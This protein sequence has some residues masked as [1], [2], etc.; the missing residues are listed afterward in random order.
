MHP[1]ITI[2]LTLFS[3]RSTLLPSCCSSGLDEYTCFSLLIALSLY[4]LY[5]VLHPWGPLRALVQMLRDRNETMP[6]TE[7]PFEHSVVDHSL[8]LLLYPPNT[9]PNTV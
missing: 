8:N 6:G 5:A 7:D 9:Y 2:V 4:D 1:V 3:L